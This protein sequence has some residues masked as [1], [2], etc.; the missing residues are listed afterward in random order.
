MDLI[1]LVF[2]SGNYMRTDENKPVKAYPV[3]RPGLVEV[4]PSQD[5]YILGKYETYERVLEEAVVA[6]GVQDSNSYMFGN[7]IE[8]LKSPSGAPL[9]Y[10]APIQFFIFN[11]E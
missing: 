11:S 8:T 10:K 1:R 6:L 9:E 2:E 4:F 7:H 3:G 5:G